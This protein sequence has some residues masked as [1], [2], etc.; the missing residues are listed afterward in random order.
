M[1]PTNLTQQDLLDFH[2]RTF[3][4]VFQVKEAAYAPANDEEDD[5]GY[6]SDGVKRT[7]T[8]K[9]I[10]IFRHSEIH[11]LLRQ[12]EAAEEA[13]ESELDVDEAP[14]K[15][16]DPEKLLS[17][18]SAL[19]DE[20]LLG[21]K[22]DEEEYARFLEQERKEFAEAA[23]KQRDKTRQSQNPHDRTVSTRRRVREMDAVVDNDVALDY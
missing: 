6:Y 1:S 19:E 15:K 2:A 10:E 3:G 20:V 8:D 21:D 22:D 18:L 4:K 17:P 14:K 11:T 13:L 5:L 23:A 12:H 9:E 16:Q 7:L